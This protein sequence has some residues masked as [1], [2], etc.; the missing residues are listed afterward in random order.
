MA[1]IDCEA[2]KL[3]IHAFN[4]YLDE[5]DTQDGYERA[6]FVVMEWVRPDHFHNIKLTT[7]RGVRKYDWL[8]DA[9]NSRKRREEYGGVGDHC[10]I[11]REDA[12]EEFR[13]MGLK[14]EDAEKH[15]QD[16]FLKT[17][18]YAPV[19]LPEDPKWRE[20]RNKAQTRLRR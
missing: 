3:N 2:A 4:Y 11:S 6:V 7:V 16:G 5:G 8:W 9:Y 19:M 15:H 14:I 1:K 12:T 20:R 18:G 13:S 17:N 10:L